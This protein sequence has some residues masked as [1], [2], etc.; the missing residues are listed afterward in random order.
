MRDGSHTIQVVFLKVTLPFVS[1]TSSVGEDMG[2]VCCNCVITSLLRQRTISQPRVRANP[3]PRVNPNPRANPNPN[4]WLR[5]CR[6]V[7]A[8][9][10]AVIGGLGVKFLMQHQC[11][12]F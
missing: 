1:P 10:F 2:R 3:N 4:P 9:S 5:S 11:S 6:Q 12:N 8:H 7:E